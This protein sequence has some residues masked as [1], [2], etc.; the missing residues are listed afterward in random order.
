MNPIDIIK[1]IFVKILAN[2][3]PI[4]ANT[5]LYTLLEKLLNDA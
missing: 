2:K 3:F 1:K 5:Y 4:I